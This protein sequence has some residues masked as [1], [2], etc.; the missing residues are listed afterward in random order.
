MC[1]MYLKWAELEQNV[2]ININFSCFRNNM[3]NG[4]RKVALDHGQTLFFQL[5]RFKIF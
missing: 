5:I 3:R 1:I 4:I 2:S